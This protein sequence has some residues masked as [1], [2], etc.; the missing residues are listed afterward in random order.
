MIRLHLRET[1]TQLGYKQG[2]NLFLSKVS[3]EQGLS[4]FLNLVRLE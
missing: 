2:L 4:L 1:L 3:S